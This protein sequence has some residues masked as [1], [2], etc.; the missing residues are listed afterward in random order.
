MDIISCLNLVGHKI[1]LIV[2]EELEHFK[3]FSA[4]LRFQIDRLQATNDEELTEKEATM[5]TGRVLTYIER[6]LVDS[7]LRIYFDEISQENR[8]ADLGATQQGV[9]VLDV[10][11]TQLNKYEEGQEHMKALPHV[12]FLMDYATQWANAIFHDI[13]EAKKR[14]VRFGQPVRLAIGHKIDHFDVRMRQSDKVLPQS[15]FMRAFVC[16]QM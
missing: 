6:Y 4:W 11:T 10:L 9:V 7:P 13:A 3:S 1:L 5:D 2:M 14:S 15:V 12:E 8:D 16:S